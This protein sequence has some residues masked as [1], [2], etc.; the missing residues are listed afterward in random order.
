MTWL[1]VEGN[2]AITEAFYQHTSPDYMAALVKTDR[3]EKREQIGVFL[4][5]FIKVY[6]G[7]L[8]VLHILQSLIMHISKYQ[9]LQDVQTKL[10]WLKYKSNL[11]KNMYILCNEEE[12]SDFPRHVHEKV[13]ADEH[14]SKVDSCPDRFTKV[15]YLMKLVLKIPKYYTAFENFCKGRQALQKYITDG[16]PLTDEMIGYVSIFL[17]FCYSILMTFLCS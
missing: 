5:Q 7:P 17:L 2:A 1:D 14:F 3:T 8:D 6:H 12:M 4:D 10:E 11:E 13:E 9:G 15:M 16:I